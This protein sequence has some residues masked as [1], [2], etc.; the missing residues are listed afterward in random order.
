MGKFNRLTTSARSFLTSSLSGASFRARARLKI[1]FPSRP[2]G[3]CW[4]NYLPSRSLK[5]KN[6]IGYAPAKVCVETGIRR[7]HLYRGS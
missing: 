4:I 5:N 2:P 3:Y 1:S 6:V 7:I